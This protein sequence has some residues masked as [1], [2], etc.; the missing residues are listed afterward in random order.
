MLMLRHLNLGAMHR[1]YRRDSCEAF[2]VLAEIEFYWAKA[3]SVVG[4][5]QAE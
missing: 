2:S 4:P 3:S 5:P 1:I